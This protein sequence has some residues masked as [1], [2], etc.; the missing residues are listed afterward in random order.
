[1]IIINKKVLKEN[2]KCYRAGRLGHRL[3]HHTIVHERDYFCC[4]AR[5]C[6]YQLI[7]QHR[8]YC[9]A[10]VEEDRK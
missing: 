3:K 4:D 8:K 9:S 1:M 10:R 7:Y 6:P 2:A 5:E